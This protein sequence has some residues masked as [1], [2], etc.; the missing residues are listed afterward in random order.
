MR[1]EW[2]EKK[3]DINLTKHRID[4]NA[5]TRLWDDEDRIQIQTRFP[6]E[7]R[8]ILERLSK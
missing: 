5:A 1:F 8:S 3:S 4:F 2:D 7:N 6:I